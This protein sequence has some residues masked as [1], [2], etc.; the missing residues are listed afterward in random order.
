[1]QPQRIVGFI[2]V[3]N[4]WWMAFIA[5]REERKIPKCERRPLLGHY[6]FIRAHLPMPYKIWFIISTLIGLLAVIVMSL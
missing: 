1:M 3:L 5:W 4:V 6:H 2:M